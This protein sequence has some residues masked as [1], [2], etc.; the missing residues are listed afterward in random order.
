MQLSSTREQIM[1][2]KQDANGLPRCANIWEIGVKKQ[3]CS[4]Y[5]FFSTEN[6][7]EAPPGG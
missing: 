1:I 7:K 4:V 2:D 6:I 5:I 3:Q